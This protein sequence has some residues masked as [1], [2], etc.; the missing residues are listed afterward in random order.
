MADMR[1]LE[2]LEIRTVLGLLP[3]WPDWPNA[4]PPPAAAAWT[5]DETK[6][7]HYLQDL[8]YICGSHKYLIL[9]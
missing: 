9:I 7:K 5:W 6:I 3:S 8:N 2:V 4:A 1:E